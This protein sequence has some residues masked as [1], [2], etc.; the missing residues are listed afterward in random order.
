LSEV[1]VDGL[2]RHQ[3]L[4]SEVTYGLDPAGTFFSMGEMLGASSVQSDLQED[5][6]Q[7]SLEVASSVLEY[8]LGD[9]YAGSMDM[10]LDAFWATDWDQPDDFYSKSAQYSS[11]TGSWA[12]YWGAAGA[13]PEGS[14]HAYAGS[15]K[16]SKRGNARIAGSGVYMLRS[17]SGEVLYVGRSINLDARKAAHRNNPIYKNAKFS[18]LHKNL[19]Y[20]EMR[21]LEQVEMDK[22]DPKNNKIR[23]VSHNN[24]NRTTY[25]QAAASYLGK[26]RK[27]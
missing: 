7:N 11:G 20:N 26:K 27:R 25:A 14:G 15:G 3:Y 5:W 22:R 23:G 4:G 13:E 10:W 9:L 16:G 19:T 6:T 8:L 12:E 24:P 2:S 18:V 21:G 1:Y 17:S